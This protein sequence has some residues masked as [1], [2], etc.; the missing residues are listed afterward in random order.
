M[1]GE[2]KTELDKLALKL[3]QRAADNDTTPDAAVD[4]FKAAATYYL[5]TQRVTKG[6]PQ[7]DETGVSFSQI[8]HKVRTNAK[9]GTA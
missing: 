2:I 1:N 9:G 4:I 8:L 7:E 6:K 3:L 5:G